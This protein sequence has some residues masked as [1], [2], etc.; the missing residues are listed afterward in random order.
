MVVRE[1]SCRSILNRSGIPGID[2]A[3]NP[4]V[5]CG[6]KCQYCYAV[7]M[8]RFTGHTEPWGDFVDVKTNAPEVLE[9]QVR[10]LKSSS[11]ISFGTVCDPYQPIEEKY[12]LTRHCLEKLVPYKHEVSILTKSNL[13]LRDLDILQRLK[14]CEVGF[15]ITS[16]N[17]RIK[18]IFEP[19]SPPAAQRFTTLKK[20]T[21]CGIQTWVFVAPILPALTDSEIDIDSLFGHAEKAGAEYIMFDTLNPYPKV[22]RNVRRTVEKYFPERLEFLDYY[23][24]NQKKY[25]RHLKQ[26]IHRIGRSYEIQHRVVF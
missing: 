24:N 16:L 13:V 8:K 21:N 12:E 2:Y 6:H 25:A 22:R 4:Y 17:R 15:T 5:G 19:G 26:L 1:I 11:T 20:L 9:Q 7:F 23:F 3:I 18:E 14:D 10:R